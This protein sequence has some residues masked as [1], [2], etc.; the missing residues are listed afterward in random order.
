MLI[1]RVLSEIPDLGVWADGLCRAAEMSLFIAAIAE[2]RP[3]I[4]LPLPMRTEKWAF[5]AESLPRR[6][7]MIV[8]M[9]FFR[10]CG[11]QEE[12]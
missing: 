1:I 4:R 11:R 6:Q 3:S 2:K 10:N 5:Q 9:R 8:G 12:E 7:S